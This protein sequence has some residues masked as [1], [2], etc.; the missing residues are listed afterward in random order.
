[1]LLLDIPGTA[2]HLKVEGSSRS[3]E[4]NLGMTRIHDTE[5]PV[6]VLVVEKV[7]MVISTS[8]ILLKCPQKT[9]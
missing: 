1:M 5:G 7:E 2:E 3:L 4:A 8:K 6:L 9:Y